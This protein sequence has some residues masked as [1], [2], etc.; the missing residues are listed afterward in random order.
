MKKKAAPKHRETTINLNKKK[1]QMIID[2]WE[3][4][5]GKDE[6]SYAS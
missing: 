1:C 2:Y 3:A 4:D 6:F 5:H